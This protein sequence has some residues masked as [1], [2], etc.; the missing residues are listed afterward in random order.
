MGAIPMRIYR[1][2]LGLGWRV[3][4]RAPSQAH[5]CVPN[6]GKIELS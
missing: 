4:P 2:S 3:V 5:I 6:I 1:L